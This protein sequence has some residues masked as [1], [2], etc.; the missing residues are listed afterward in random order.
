MRRSLTRRTFLWLAGVAGTAMLGVA[1]LLWSRRD[2]VS[3]SIIEVAHNVSPGPHRIG[4][5]TLVME[6]SRGPAEVFQRG[7]RA[8]ET[9]VT[10][11]R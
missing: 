11:G 4:A 2:L 3:G 7:A 1:Y 5:F 9:A 6:I 10:V 8:P